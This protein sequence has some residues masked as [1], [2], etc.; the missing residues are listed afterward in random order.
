MNGPVWSAGRVGE[1]LLFDGT[2]DYVDLGNLDV[3][4][5][6]LTLAAW[7]NVNEFN[8]ND[9]RILSKATGSSTQD[10]YWMLS[11]T[12]DNG[13][14][15]AR[16]RLKT[17]GVTSTLVAD[18]GSVPIGGW[19]H[20]AA[21]YDGIEMRLYQDGVL[22]GTQPKTGTVTSGAGVPVW[23]GG[24]PTSNLQVWDGLI[25][26]VRIYS[27]ALTPAEVQ[28]LAAG[29]VNN[30]PPT[31]AAGDD[32]VI[33]LPTAA[34]LDGSA[35]DDGLPQGGSLTFGWSQ[36]AG[37]G[38]ASFTDA[39]ALD[40]TVSFSDP[41][42]YTLTLTV[43]DGEFTVSDDVLI[44]VNAPAPMVP[45]GL[46]VGVVSGSELLVSWGDVSGEDSYQLQVDDGVTGFVEVSGSPLVAGTL[47]FA[48]SGLTAGTE[49][50]FRVQ[51]S[52]AGGSSGFSVP[53]CATPQVVVTSRFENTSAGLVFSSPGW[54]VSSSASRSGGSSTTTVATG[55][56]LNVAF[57]GSVV[58]LL[59]STGPN[60]GKATVSVDGGGAG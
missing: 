14:E 21:T 43:G 3:A 8:P 32:Q 55:A 20:V 19:V 26:D 60:R 41:G 33:V 4:S 24:N 11:T 59:A 18:S 56:S 51:A 42:D 58:R 36:T 45:S 40:T 48:A 39:G 49:Y 50:C 25:D 15:R 12:E 34:A 7:I 46:S 22:V 53:V 31:V 6:Q 1:A 29:S 44:T 10:H 30:Q 16:F 52:N 27:E 17:D 57:E 2:D 5:D 35:A 47:S 13:V 28:A 9:G 23:I 54:W 38:T 37:T